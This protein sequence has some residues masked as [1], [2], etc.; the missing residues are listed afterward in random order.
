MLIQSIYSYILLIDFL[1][2][3]D[4]DDEIDGLDDGNALI[5]SW[6]FKDISFCFGCLILKPRFF[7][8]RVEIKIFYFARKI[9]SLLGGLVKCCPVENGCRL[10]SIKLL[11]FGGL[12]QTSMVS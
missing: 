12:I 5:D 11:R 3:D 4:D 1:E 6:D 8:E 7:C 9:D 2:L 10:K